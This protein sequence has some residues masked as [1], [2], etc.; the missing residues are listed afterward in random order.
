MTAAMLSLAA[1][2][3]RDMRNNTASAD[4]TIRRCREMIKSMVMSMEDDIGTKNTARKLGKIV[5]EFAVYGDSRPDIHFSQPAGGFIWVSL[6]AITEATSHKVAL[7]TIREIQSGYCDQVRA[8]E[9][10][11]SN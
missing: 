10:F 7:D 5:S 2:F 4:A 11:Y 9:K 6:K 1:S 8:M 3:E